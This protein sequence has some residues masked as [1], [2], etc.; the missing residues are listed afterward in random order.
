MSSAVCNLRLARCP[1][2]P[3]PGKTW[4]TN[5]VGFDVGAEVDVEVEVFDGLVHAVA[6]VRGDC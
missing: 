5:L 3:D 4:P 2:H 6:V 1:L